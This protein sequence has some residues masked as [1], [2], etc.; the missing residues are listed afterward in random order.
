MQLSLWTTPTQLWH[1]VWKICV[2]CWHWLLAHWLLF[3]KIIGVIIAVVIMYKYLRNFLSN[4]Y[5][6]KNEKPVQS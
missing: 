2:K 6:F 1:W 4:Y 3:A 5:K